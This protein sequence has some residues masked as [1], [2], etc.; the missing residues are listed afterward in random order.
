M[1]RQTRLSVEELI[2][3]CESK[4]RSGCQSCACS[5]SADPMPACFLINEIGVCAVA[6]ND[7]TAQ[8]Y[9]IGLLSHSEKEYQ[10]LA[11][12]YLLQAGHLETGDKFILDSFKAKKKNSLLV[13]RADLT[14]A[15]Y[16][17]RSK[18]N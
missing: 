3:T 14:I 8:K 16:R 7:R 6:E 11:L 13:Q 4:L 15:N 12:V 17:T 10:F 18:L 2:R 9:L 5:R 1:E